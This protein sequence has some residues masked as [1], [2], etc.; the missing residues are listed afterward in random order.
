MDNLDNREPNWA[1]LEKIIPKEL[2]GTWMW[3]GHTQV[4]TCRVEQYKHCETRGYLNLDGWGRAWL[5]RFDPDGVD[6]TPSIARPITLNSAF[7]AALLKPP[8]LPIEDGD[9]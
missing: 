7:A 6:E 3:M 9:C 1:P 2:L 5:I 4:G 8:G